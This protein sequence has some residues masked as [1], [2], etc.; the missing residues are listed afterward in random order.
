MS[1]DVQARIALHA[2]T[3]Y[4]QEASRIGYGA[5]HPL[6]WDERYAGYQRLKDVS[7]LPGDSQT[8]YRHEEDPNAET[9]TR[10]QPYGSVRYVDHWDGGNLSDRQSLGAAYDDREANPP[11]GETGH[12]PA[13][14]SPDIAP[15]DS[16]LGAFGSYL[17]SGSIADHNRA[18]WVGWYTPHHRGFYLSPWHAQDAPVLTWWKSA[19]QAPELWEPRL[20]SL[21]AH[22]GPDPDTSAR[23]DLHQ[24]NATALVE[25]YFDGHRAEITEH[26]PVGGPPKLFQL[27]RHEEPPFAEFGHLVHL[28]GS[29]ASAGNK[30]SHSQRKLPRLVWH[31]GRT[32]E[33]FPGPMLASQSEYYV[34]GNGGTYSGYTYNRDVYPSG[35][36]GLYPG[37]TGENPGLIDG[38]PYDQLVGKKVIRHFMDDVRNDVTGE[39]IGERAF[40]DPHPVYHPFDDDLAHSNPRA[41]LV[42]PFDGTATGDPDSNRRYDVPGVTPTFDGNAARWMG[43][44]TVFDYVRDGSGRIQ[45]FDGPGMGSSPDPDG[46]YVRLTPK[47]RRDAN[48]EA[49]VDGSGDPIFVQQGDPVPESVGR[50]WF[51]IWRESHDT[52]VVTVGAGASHGWRI[53]GGSI[54][55]RGSEVVSDEPCPYASVDELRDAIAAEVRYSY[56]VCWQPQV[57]VTRIWE[58]FPQ[59]SSQAGSIKYVQ[60][61]KSDDLVALD[62]AG[63]DW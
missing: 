49:V 13:I 11:A 43:A 12:D 16:Q 34:G 33:A 58:R 29:A 20:R 47:V 61:L 42:D 53:R 45:T 32:W 46:A 63:A 37:G 22:L 26:W 10:F 62:A 54:E 25:Q 51:R 44:G 60:R 35:A 4:L 28:D 55:S 41:P 21:P 18:S 36:N 31:A 9:L 50:A 1:Q 7:G 15:S 57:K 38:Y 5:G 3:C 14:A 56:R 30:L 23:G 8:P 6:A 52:F 19:R 17:S 40:F 59:W 24:V 39:W 2:A 48:G 27:F